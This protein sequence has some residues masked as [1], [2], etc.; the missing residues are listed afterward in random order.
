MA[1]QPE[2]FSRHAEELIASFRRA[3]GE[4]APRM[5]KRPTR[6]VASVLED[7]RVK[8]RIGRDHPEEI[9]RERWAELVGTANAA[10][11]H[12][13]RIEGDRRLIVQTTHSVVR[14]E[15]FLHRDEIMERVRRVP[16]CAG[17]KDLRVGA[18]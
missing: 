11:S 1:K 3:P 7:V 12:P 10:Y 17:L 4:G 18:A 8:F 6:D 16:G 15:L 9:L 14:N 5:R 13:V 2:H